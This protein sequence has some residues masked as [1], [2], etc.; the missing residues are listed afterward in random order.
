M[1]VTDSLESTIEFVS[2]PDTTFFYNNNLVAQKVI[3]NFYEVQASPEFVNGIGAGIVNVLPVYTDEN[4]NEIRMRCQVVCKYFDWV[5]QNEIDS[6]EIEYSLGIPVNNGY[7]LLY[8]TSDPLG[9]SQAMMESGL[10]EFCD[11]NFIIEYFWSS[12]IPNDEFYSKQWNIK[13]NGQIDSNGNLCLEGADIRVEGAWSLT[14][15]APDVIIGLF[16]E[17]IDADHPDLPE[18]RISR[19]PGAN[20][21]GQWGPDADTFPSDANNHGTMVAGIVGAEMNNNIGIAGIASQSR[22]TPMRQGHPFSELYDVCDIYMYALKNG[23]RILNHSGGTTYQCNSI[24]GFTEEAIE[25]GLLILRAATNNASHHD[26]IDGIVPIGFASIEH[27]IIVGASDRNNQQADY[28]PTDPLI[29]I[30]APSA[31]DYEEYDSVSGQSTFYEPISGEERNIWS[32]DIKSTNGLGQGNPWL[33]DDP[34]SIIELN[35]ELPAN[36]VYGD[37][38]DYTGRFYGTSAATPQVASV[39]ALMLAANS[40]LTV[41]ELEEILFE[42]AEKIGDTSEY[43]NGH[44]DKFGHGLVNAELAVQTALSSEYGGI[45]FEVEVV[46]FA[47]SETDGAIIQ[48]NIDQ[49][50]N[51]SVVLITGFQESPTGYTEYPYTLIE[52]DWPITLEAE[53]INFNEPVVVETIPEHLLVRVYKNNE[54]N[55]YTA[56]DENDDLI[57]PYGG[58]LCSSTREIWV[59]GPEIE[60]FVTNANCEIPASGSLLL[61]GANPYGNPNVFA[62]TIDGQLQSDTDEN[63]EVLQLTPGDHNVILENTSG[64]FCESTVHIGTIEDCCLDLQYI[65][66]ESEANIC[67]GVA[68]ASLVIQ[69][70]GG[71]DNYSFLWESEEIFSVQDELP[72]THA[73]IDNASCG[74]YNVIVEDNIFLC[75]SEFQFEIEC[76]TNENIDTDITIINASCPNIMDGEIHALNLNGGCSQNY[77]FNWT[78][79]TGFSS[80]DQVITDLEVGDYHLIVTNP[81]CGCEM[82]FDVE[83]GVEPFDEPLNVEVTSGNFTTLSQ[84]WTGEITTFQGDIIFSG[85]GIIGN[86]LDLTTFVLSDNSDIIIEEGANVTFLNCLFSSCGSNWLGFD[87][88][89]NHSST[90]VSGKLTM[91]SCTVENA[92]TGIFTSDEGLTNLNIVQRHGGNILCDGSTF[93]NCKVAFEAEHATKLTGV[94]LPGVGFRKCRFELDDQM[95]LH[96]PDTEGA[97][98]QFQSLIRFDESYG[99]SF[100]GCTF[101]N[102]MTTGIE[103]WSNRGRAIR[104]YKSVF[105]VESFQININDPAERSA[106]SGFDVAIDA[107]HTVKR[108]VI[109]RYSDFEQNRVGIRLTNMP[110]AQVYKNTISVGELSGIETLDTQE[111]VEVGYENGEPEYAPIWYEGIFYNGGSNFV[112]AENSIDGTTEAEGGVDNDFERIGIRVRDTNTEDD[113]VYKNILTDLHVGNKAEGNNNDNFDVGG[114]RYVCNENARN[115]FDFLAESFDSEELAVG[116][117]Q[118]DPGP[119]DLDPDYPADNILTSD[120]FALLDPQ[121]GHYTNMGDDIVYRYSG[122]LGPDDLNPSPEQI[123]IGLLEVMV[124]AN[125]CITRFGSEHNVSHVNGVLEKAAEADEDYQDSKFIYLSLL[126]EGNTAD[127]RTTVMN[128]YGEDVLDRRD[129]LLAISPYVSRSVLMTVANRPDQYPDAIAFE[130]FMANADILKDQR[131]INHLRTKT[132]PMEEYMVQM[133]EAAASQSTQRTIL[134]EE[135]GLYRSRYMQNMGDALFWM[136]SL[137]DYDDGDFSF[138]I[139]DMLTLQT[140]YLEIENK[141]DNGNVN[142]AEDKLGALPDLIR[143]DDYA[144]A[145]YNSMVTWEEHRA[146][147]V[148]TSRYWNDLTVQ[149]LDN[150]YNLLDGFNLYGGR[151]AMQILNFYYDENFQIP[152]S[153]N[154]PWDPRSVQLEDPAVIECKLFPNP[155]NDIIYVEINSGINGL[156]RL[157]MTVSDLNG[158]VLL[159]FEIKDTDN[160]LTLDSRSWPSGLYLFEIHSADSIV[161]NGKFEISH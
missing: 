145:D 68:D 118:W 60:S 34:T 124:E 83:V 90:A 41:P 32:L 126:D 79:P 43:V 104:S 157:E 84:E 102:T 92:E 70:T 148:N 24:D 98:S 142:D 59:K 155:S 57:N 5:S 23:V 46:N 95:A 39:A 134:E 9:V 91:N 61:Q 52:T 153:Y 12:H 21:G 4:G 140:E 58:Q 161:H 122:S 40:C 66:L 120:N 25:N 160:V 78:G 114:L 18:H 44:S 146:A 77:E 147:L 86:S 149:E 106:F 30:V 8:N 89:A 131:F 22:L 111:Q 121:G 63:M 51:Y 107:T 87:V 64:D 80:T 100:Q 38:L 112:L 127:L 158:R 6:L 152:P 150:L 35:E 53:T 108:P 119:S 75:S 139:E 113:E 62:W 47:C 26:G 116:S 33:I 82:E 151:C 109:V 73:G 76:T 74:D 129:D 94:N 85:S 29:D 136:A 3:E 123:G 28:S 67:P 31:S 132:L 130:I 103:E 50:Q 1:L 128:A 56:L 105:R 141:L 97:Y 143:L 55:S 45:D 15:G 137:D 20:F 16:N 125:V 144:Y 11:P 159:S 135:L 13:N 96:F 93:R 72:A 65:E 14:T 156:D 115:V 10:V 71:S 27:V 154:Q 49:P 37:H 110:F 117:I 69:I 7:V 138:V 42:T 2:Q 88:R 48:V 99:Y 54:T 17:S 36:S 133:L 19:L 81:D 101:E